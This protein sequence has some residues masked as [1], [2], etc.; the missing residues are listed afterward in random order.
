MKGIL[1]ELSRRQISI[2]IQLEC[3]ASVGVGG[4]PLTDESI[5]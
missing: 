4:V 3:E 2:L 1:V 5:V